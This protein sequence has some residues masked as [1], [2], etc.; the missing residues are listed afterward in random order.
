MT[1][2]PTLLTGLPSRQNG[3]AL[4]AGLL[5]L[6]VALLLGITA[7]NST[8]MQERMAGNFRDVSLA[9]QASEAGSRWAAAW[10]LSRTDDIQDRLVPCSDPCA[11]ND[12]VR[13]R[14]VYGYRPDSGNP[15]W[16][17][18]GMY[19]WYGL[20]PTEDVLVEPPQKFAPDKSDNPW[21]I[22]DQPRF[23][24][25][26]VGP[27]T[28][29]AYGGVVLDDFAGNPYGPVLTGTFYYRVTSL[30]YGARE[31]SNAIIS[32]VVRKRAEL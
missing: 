22:H 28:E 30:G 29:N 2:S 20:D 27:D 8:I 10:V 18:T 5:I 3:S 16:E 17:T 6:V 12:V 14:G 11:A 7:T 24:I 13:A 21:I 1:N 9:F 31:N 32:T 15:L 19:R 4:L 26:T 25:E 23:I